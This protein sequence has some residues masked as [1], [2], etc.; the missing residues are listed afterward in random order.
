MPQGFVKRN[1]QGKE[2]ALLLH[3]SSECLKQSAANW[4]ELLFAELK[5]L[6]FEKNTKEPCLFKL[7][8]TDGSL[9]VVL[10][11][12]DD[13]FGVIKPT[14]AN[15][16]WYDKFVKSLSEIAPVKGQGSWTDP[17]GTWS[18]CRARR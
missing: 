8:M 12:V 10:I 9:V 17:E 13:V 14:D 5:S 18:Y 6:G 7:E 2:L 11:Y 15:D 1:E 3:K 16:E 4:Q